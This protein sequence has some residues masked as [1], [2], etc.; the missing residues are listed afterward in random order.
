[1]EV[2]D[3]ESMVMVLAFTKKIKEKG[4]R[5]RSELRVETRRRGNETKQRAAH[6]TDPPLGILVRRSRDLEVGYRRC[7]RIW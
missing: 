7:E 4:R 1:M 3:S 6:K 5:G 2:E